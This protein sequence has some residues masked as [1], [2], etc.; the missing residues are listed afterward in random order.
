[1][2]DKRMKAW[3]GNVCKTCGNYTYSCKCESEYS[4]AKIDELFAIPRAKEEKQMDMETLQLEA[5]NILGA[6]EGESLLQVAHRVSEQLS[7]MNDFARRQYSQPAPS[8]TGTPREI[9][10]LP[11][12]QYAGNQPAVWLDDWRH[13]RARAEKAETALSQAKRDAEALRI[14]GE[15]KFH[16]L[17][18]CE[19]ALLGTAASR[20]TNHDLLAVIEL[21]LAD[22]ALA[23]R[24]GEGNA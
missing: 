18:A 4:R 14:D 2:S 20:A 23:K 22:A 17:V 24:E 16:L 15:R 8:Q 10:Y 1:M 3:V 5:M 6:V 19:N 11:R 7:M 12:P 21:E 13:M 9:F